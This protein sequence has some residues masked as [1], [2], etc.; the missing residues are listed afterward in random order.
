MKCPVCGS[1][2]MDYKETITFSN[3]K[4]ADIYV[5]CECGCAKRDYR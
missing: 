1:S 3:G 2:N 4:V 5:C